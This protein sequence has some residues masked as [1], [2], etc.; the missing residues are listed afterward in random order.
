MCLFP[1]VINISTA[2]VSGCG[3]IYELCGF[4]AEKSIRI[5][6]I[7]KRKSVSA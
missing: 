6:C 7:G 5:S 3:N 4:K 1:L 2:P